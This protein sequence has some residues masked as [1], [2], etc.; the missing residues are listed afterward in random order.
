MVGS[1]D[2]TRTRVH[3]WPA[4][5]GSCHWTALQRTGAVRPP[6]SANPDPPGDW[7]RDFTLLPTLDNAGPAPAV[8]TLGFSATPEL[9]GRSWELKNNNNDDDD[10]NRRCGKRESRKENERTKEKWQAGAAREVHTC[11]R[12]QSP[13]R[14]LSPMHS[15]ASRTLLHCR[16]PEWVP[17]SPPPAPW[18]EFLLC[19]FNLNLKSN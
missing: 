9:W 8:Y 11:K 7:K 6:S 5:F 10:K 2:R 1:T 17:L 4:S 13:R 16:T 19:S 12:T 14:S 3:I 18:A 15:S